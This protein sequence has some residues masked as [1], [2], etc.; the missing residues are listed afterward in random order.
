MK[1]GANQFCEN[2]IEEVQ[3]YFCNHS[4]FMYQN[5]SYRWHAKR[6]KRNAIYSVLDVKNNVSQL[7]M[8]RLDIENK[9]QNNQQKIK[10]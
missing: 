8:F 6:I 5:I 10:K 7:F 2:R 3:E 9:T 1:T 4:F